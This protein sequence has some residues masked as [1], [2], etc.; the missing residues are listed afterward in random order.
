MDDEFPDELIAQFCSVTECDEEV[1]RQYIAAA[2]GDVEA[3]VGLFLDGD[4]SPPGGSR[5]PATAAP[6]F[7]AEP[8]VRAPIAPKRTVL[9]EDDMNEGDGYFSPGTTHRTFNVGDYPRAPPSAFATS[10]TEPFRDFH[11]EL[12]SHTGPFSDRSLVPADDHGRR[13]AELFRPPTEIIFAGS[14]DAARRAAK[15]EHRWLLVTLH[16]PAEF[17]CQQ[18]IRDVWNDAAVQDFIREALVFSF[19]TVGTQEGNRYMQFY[20]LDSPDGWPH[21]ALI[22]PR[23]GRR[24]RVGPTRALRGPE[25]LN[26]LAEFVADHALEAATAS[27]TPSARFDG[28]DCEAIQKGSWP[29]E[30]VDMTSE[31]VPAPVVSELSPDKSSQPT[32]PME[33]E[34]PADDPDAITIQLRMPDGVRHRRRFLKSTPAARIFDYVYSLNPDLRHIPFDIVHAQDV[35]LGELRDRSMDSLKLRNATLIVKLAHT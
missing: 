10:P 13:L 28:S 31:T 33:L 15:N 3:A 17:P 16:N 21:W 22:D 1:A 32:I 11:A 18:M 8:Q 27:A 34:P 14:L 12:L 2:D 29:T 30:S 7:E 5:A 19:L 4:G 24:V 26:E 6:A 35:S 23:T 25:M 9:V 20:P